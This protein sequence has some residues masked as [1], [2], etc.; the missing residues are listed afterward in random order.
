M[1]QPTSVEN[2]DLFFV[3]LTVAQQE[4]LRRRFPSVPVTE[5]LQ[6]VIDEALGEGA[7]VWDVG[8]PR[9]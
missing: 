5:A 3:E 9:E 1:S 7:E 4:A 6:R 2:Q 8:K